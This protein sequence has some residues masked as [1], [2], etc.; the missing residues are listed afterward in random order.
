MF[1]PEAAFDTFRYRRQAALVML[2][3][4]LKAK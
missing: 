4:A 2:A 3:R 1:N